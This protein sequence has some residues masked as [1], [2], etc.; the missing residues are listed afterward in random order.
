MGVDP[1]N[2]PVMAAIYGYEFNGELW[3]LNDQGYP[4]LLL[5]PMLGWLEQ[6][7]YP[8]D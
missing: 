2:E 6:L 8:E 3:R 4:E 1:L 7:H 5:K